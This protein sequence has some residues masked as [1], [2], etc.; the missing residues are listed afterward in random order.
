LLAALFLTPFASFASA[1]RPAVMTSF[2]HVSTQKE[3]PS[4]D[5]IG[6]YDQL[7]P[8]AR[9]W[10][11]TADCA[12]IPLPTARLDSVQFYFVNAVDFAPWPTDKPNSMVQGVT[13]AAREQIYISILRARDESIVKHEMLHQLLYWY[14][15][16]DWH[17][18]A[19]VEFERCALRVVP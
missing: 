1:Q 2:R 13:Y 17:D 18:D 6:L 15:E 10:R 8:Y 5:W 9:W 4:L 16:L 7:S 19:R 11:E 14:D 3:I 12:G